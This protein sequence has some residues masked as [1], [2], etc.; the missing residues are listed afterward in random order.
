MVRLIYPQV[1]DAFNAVDSKEDWRDMGPGDSGEAG[2]FKWQWVEAEPTETQI[3]EGKKKKKKKGL[4]ANI[5]AKRARGEK[6]AKPGDKNYP[7]QK[8]LKAAQGK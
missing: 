1:Q 2:E 8:S 5:H 6:P 3:D 7:D 4:W